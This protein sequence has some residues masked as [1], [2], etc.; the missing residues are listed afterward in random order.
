MHILKL[1][2]IFI[3]ETQMREIWLQTRE[4]FSCCGNNWP[5]LYD[6]LFTLYAAIF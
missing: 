3:S 4:R 1:P 6:L 5:L 2:L